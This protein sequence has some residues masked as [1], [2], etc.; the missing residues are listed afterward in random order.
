MRLF[1]LGRVAVVV[2]V[3]GAASVVDSRCDLLEAGGGAAEWLM[4]GWCRYTGPGRLLG[5]G[6][7]RLTYLK[8]VQSWTRRLFP[9]C[10]NTY[11][12]KKLP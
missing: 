1:G 3:V 12:E 6:G 11:W 10:V 5:E 8:R 7:K 9:G 2:V 4:G